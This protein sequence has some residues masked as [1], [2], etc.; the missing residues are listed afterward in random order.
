V[1]WFGKG[2]SLTAP[3]GGADVPATPEALQK[4]LTAASKMCG[5]GLVKAVVLDLTRP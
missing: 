2:V 1:L 4:A 5:T 3:P